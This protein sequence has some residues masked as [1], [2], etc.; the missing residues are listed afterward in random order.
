MSMMLTWDAYH[1]TDESAKEKILPTGYFIKS[2]SDTEWAGSGIYFF[3]EHGALDNA[4]KWAKYKKKFP[5]PTVIKAK[6]KVDNSKLFDLT[7][8]DNQDL[9]HKLRTLYF[10]KAQQLAKE[11]NKRIGVVASKKMNLDCFIINQ[12]CEKFDYYAVKR[13]CYIRFQSRGKWRE[14]PASDIPNSTI[15]CIRDPE[16]IVSI[17]EV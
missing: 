15:V 8:P 5:R 3:V 11:N 2:T 6:I 4:M 14:Y 17:S 10:E 7:I 1:G 9:F 12:I 13:T 16:C